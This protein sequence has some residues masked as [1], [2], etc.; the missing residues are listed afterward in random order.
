VPVD[1]P[2][3]G[4]PGGCHVPCTETL[5]TMRS[6]PATLELV[7]LPPSLPCPLATGWLYHTDD[8]V[9]ARRSP[10]KAGLRGLHEQVEGRPAVL[11]QQ[12]RRREWV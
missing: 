5:V 9:A 8:V 11:T 1:T 3:R 4:L 7:L 12:H 6:A 2:D 10:Q